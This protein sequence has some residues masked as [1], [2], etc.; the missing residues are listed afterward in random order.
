MGVKL[1]KKLKFY[2]RDCE[3]KEDKFYGINCAYSGKEQYSGCFCYKC[4]EEL[5]CVM[6][7]TVKGVF[8]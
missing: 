2:M 6:R 4:N 8:K 5:D 3:N 7:D 1:L